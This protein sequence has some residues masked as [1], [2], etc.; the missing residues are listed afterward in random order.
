MS[1]NKWRYTGEIEKKLPAMGVWSGSSF[2]RSSWNIIG[3][4]G[5]VG[6][7]ALISDGTAMGDTTNSL[8]VSVNAGS[9]SS[10]NVWDVR[11][12]R[13]TSSSRTSLVFWPPI[14]CL[15]SRRSFRSLHR[16]R[17]RELSSMSEPISERSLT[18][19]VVLSPIWARTFSVGAGTSMPMLLGV[20]EL[21]FFLKSQLS[22]QFPSPIIP[23]EM[24]PISNREGD[25]RYM[26]WMWS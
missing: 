25:N 16:S 26:L 14:R 3:G 18:S 9:C 2:N 22:S 12:V 13:S 19:S 21:R 11:L 10:S 15:L 20:A 17:S 7:G 5:G 24:D 1:Y 6:D 23:E 4:G 8:V